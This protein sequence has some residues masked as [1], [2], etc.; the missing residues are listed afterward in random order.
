[1][2]KVSLLFQEGPTW[3]VR[4]TF[5]FLAGTFCV[6]IILYVVV[7]WNDIS[8][9]SPLVIG[10]FGVLGTVVTAYVGGTVY[11]EHGEKKEETS[12]ALDVLNANEV[13]QARQMKHDEDFPTL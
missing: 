5:V 4:R 11:K 13:R 2:K 7:R 3:S 6:A 12:Q 9:A 1:M 10:A 8:F